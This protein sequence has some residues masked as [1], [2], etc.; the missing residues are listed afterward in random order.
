MVQDRLQGIVNVQGNP[1]AF[2][3]VTEEGSLVTWGDATLGGDSS[4]IRSKLQQKVRQ[5]TPSLK[6]FFAILEDW[7]LIYWGG[8][9]GIG[10]SAVKHQLTLC[11]R[12]A[13][14]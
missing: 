14:Q 12:S 8:T 6:G 4:V 2:A 11:A 13:P 5:V 1:S 10:M 7:S 3:A 9:S